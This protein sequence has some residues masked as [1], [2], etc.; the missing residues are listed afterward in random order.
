MRSNVLALILVLSFCGKASGEQVVSYGDA[1]R[2]PDGRF[3]ATYLGS[4]IRIEDNSGGALSARIGVFSVLAFNW[5]GDSKTVVTV[6]HLAGGS[7][8]V[9]IHLDDGQWRR[10]E[11]DPVDDY[12]AAAVIG[13]IIRDHSVSVKYRLRK[14][15]DQ[16]FQFYVCS[17]DVDSA[18][19]NRTNEKVKRISA[20]KYGQLKLIEDQAS[21]KIGVRVTASP[22]PSQR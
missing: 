14:R 1:I 20:A 3:L 13:L 9:L 15:E 5:T 12:D 22:S 19:H 7:E 18:T 8:A 4:H 10:F 6:E 21:V 2:S 11:I 17:F 16:R